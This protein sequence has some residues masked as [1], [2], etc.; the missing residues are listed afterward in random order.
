MLDEYASQNSERRGVNKDDSEE[1]SGV[2]EALQDTLCDS[3]G[4]R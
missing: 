2:R 4:E 1:K 3:L